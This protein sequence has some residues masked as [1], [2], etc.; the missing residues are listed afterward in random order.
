MNKTNDESWKRILITMNAGI[1]ENTEKL[2][3]VLIQTKEESAKLP[4]KVIKLAKVP[5]WSKDLSLDIFEKQIRA[6]N[7]INA[8]VSE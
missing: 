5:A 7:E 1:K 3:G 8:D 2:C 6:W 4:S